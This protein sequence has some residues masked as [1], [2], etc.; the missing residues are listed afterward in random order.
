MAAYEDSYKS[1][2]QGVSQQVP[3]ERLDGQV[4]E[5]TNMLSDAVTNLRRRPGSKFL[6]GTTVGYGY[7]PTDFAA[8]DAEVGDVP[9]TVLV[10]I[11]SGVLRVI[12][13]AGTVVYTSGAVPYL[14]AT[15]VRS[16]QTAPIVDSLYILNTERVVGRGPVSTD[17][18]PGTGGFFYIRAGAFNKKFTVTVQGGT[19]TTTQSYSTPLGTV[20]GDAANATPEFIAQNLATAINTAT[21]TTGAQAHVDGAF[22]F[23]ARV[24]GNTDV[25]VTS[26]AGLSF[27]VAS[28]T[29]Y[30]R[31]E[32]DLPAKLP[33][34]ANGWLVSTGDARNKR[35]YRY[36][37]T[38]QAWLETGDALSPTSLMN[39]PVSL[40]QSNGAWALESSTFEGR[41]AGDDNTNPDPT[42]VGRTV[43]G[44]AAYQGRLVLLSGNMVHLSASNLPRRF[45]RSTVGS[46]LDNDPIGIGAAGTSTSVYRYAVQY[47]KD[48]ILFS[49]RMQAVIPGS[50]VAITPRTAAVL[51][52]SEYA[53]DMTMQPLVVG[54]SLMF[55]APR[56]ST[57]FGFMEML[58]STQTESQYTSTDATPHLPTYM[59]GRCRFGLS[60]TV[61]SMALFGNTANLRELF[62][63]EY[64]WQGD[65]KVQAAW[66]RWEF[67]FP[68]AT[69]HYSDGAVTLLFYHADQMVAAQIEPQGAAYEGQDR[70]PFLDLYTYVEAYDREAPTPAWLAAFIPEDEERLRLRLSVAQGPMAGSGIEMEYV[71]GQLRTGKSFPAGRC[72]VG[73]PYLSS[74]TPTAPMRKDRKG[75]RVSTNKMTVLRFVVSTLRSGEFNVRVADKGGEV[76]ADV[77]SPVY[78]TSSELQLGAAVEGGDNAVVIPARTRAEQTDLTLSTDGMG[79]LNLVG[80]EF[81]AQYHAKLQRSGG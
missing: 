33:A 10:N 60:S 59:E 23:I 7:E 36:S 76:Y 67:P 42:F 61:S 35:Y 43:T 30:I 47:Q 16:L 21:A 58:P 77:Y 12:D 39:M 44:M 71:N 79:Q 52:T 56:S 17:P 64:V 37:S 1:Q 29:G 19:G 80:L 27:V 22:V 65:E 74:I 45:Y 55:A 49:D 18:V 13:R 5:Q 25:N 75:V 66:H 38:D 73:F 78:Y 72:A 53:A 63:H 15:N 31:Q 40:S 2:L 51:P 54:R 46:L 24:D 6:W 50:N 26:D 20:A 9:C 48:L 14:V 57:H 3:R 8:W 34:Q 28:G 68:V 32:S 41:L 4:S 81:V 70:R 62:V 69:A 11:K